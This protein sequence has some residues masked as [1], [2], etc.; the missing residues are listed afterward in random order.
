LVGI[1][2][3][4]LWLQPIL[5][6]VLS[7]FGLFLLLQTITIRLR[8]TPKDLEVYRSGNLIRSFPYEEWENWRIFWNPI[9]IL[10][11]FKEV[12]SI[13]FL[14]II[15]DVNSLKSCLEKYNCPSDRSVD[16]P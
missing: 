11:Y 4:L 15:F 7:V 2:L 13:H 9:P 3:P 8:F 12:K 16:L 6:L 10:F 1:S 14:P 5:G